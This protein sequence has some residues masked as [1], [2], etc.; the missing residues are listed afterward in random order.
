MFPALNI[1]CYSKSIFIAMYGLCFINASCHI[2]HVLILI[3]C[4]NVS[5]SNDGAELIT[6]TALEFWKQGRD[7]QEIK[8]KDLEKYISES[9]FN[10]TLGKQNRFNLFATEKVFDK[11]EA[12]LVLFL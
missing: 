7:R 5:C 6:Q 2:S 4:L 12:S 1:Y 8:L 10:N 9:V 11:R 3:C